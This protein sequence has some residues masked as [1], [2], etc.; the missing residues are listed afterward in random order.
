MDTYQQNFTEILSNLTAGRGVDGSEP[1]I[2]SLLRLQ[3]RQDI[4]KLE[5]Y[6][7]NIENKLTTAKQDIVDIKW[8]VSI[9]GYVELDYAEKE[10]RVYRSTDPSLF[11]LDS[12][13]M[14]KL[15]TCLTNEDPTEKYWEKVRELIISFQDLQSEAKILW[16][17]LL[18]LQEEFKKLE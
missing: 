10:A 8:K 17:Y 4:L 16:N 5:L 18:Y 12:V 13:Y 14:Q 2:R 6:L 9:S 15:Q 1:S 11:F 3:I 7:S